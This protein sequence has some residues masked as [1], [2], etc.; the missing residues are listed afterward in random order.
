MNSRLA[1]WVYGVLAG[2]A[3][4]PPRCRGVAAEH[5]VELIRHAGL[6]AVASPVPLDRF[7]TAALRQSLEDMETLETLARRHAH[8]LD[9]AL[10]IGPVVPF[11]LCAVFASERGVRTM[12]AREHA[13]L[14]DALR[15]LSGMT[16]WGVKAYVTDPPAPAAAHPPASGVEYLTR[17]RAERAGHADRGTIVD[18]VHARLADRAAG[19]VLCAPQDPRLSGHAGRMALN[20]AYLVAG[21]DA[22]AFAEIVSQAGDRHRDDGIEVELSGPWPAYHFPRGPMT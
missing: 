4:R 19:A 7:D 15:Q 14:S 18:A 22:G 13:E 16:E 1:Q 6:A 8:V 21:S 3:P 11:G 5:D 17:R 2:D 9:G 12:L 20:A 10:R